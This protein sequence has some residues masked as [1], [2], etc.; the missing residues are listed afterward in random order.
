MRYRMLALLVVFVATTRANGRTPPKIVLVESYSDARPIGMSHYMAEIVAGLG[1][2][3][4]AGDELREKLEALFSRPAGKAT[5]DDL[6]ALVAKASDGANAYGAANFNIAVTQLAQ[7]VDA[8]AREPAALVQNAK[9]RETRKEALLT[10]AK[11]LAKLHR[12]SDA[13]AAIAEAV[14]SYPDLEFSEAVYPPNIVQLGKAVQ[15]ERS[16]HPSTT[17]VIETTPPGKKVY[18]NE[19][20]LGVTPQTVK[21]LAPG[22]YRVYFPAMGKS[23]RGASPTGR[24]IFPSLATSK[25][26]LRWRNT[27]ACGSRQWHD[28]ERQKFQSRVRHVDRSGQLFGPIPDL[29]GDVLSGRTTK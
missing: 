28:S 5:A 8:L 19:Q 22:A 26:T 15:K 21:G 9:L 29:R 20:P 1:P 12:E 16:A 25:I 3:V 18:L 27:S 6:Q 7:V 17:L 11:A 2:G 14:R 23:A 4:L 24:P 10:L 13:R